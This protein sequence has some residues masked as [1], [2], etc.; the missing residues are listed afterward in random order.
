VRF[1]Q[2]IVVTHECREFIGVLLKKDP[3][4]RIGYKRD[5]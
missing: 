3:K 4:E 5:Y 1:S 2:N